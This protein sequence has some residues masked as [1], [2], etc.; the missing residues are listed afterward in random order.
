MVFSAPFQKESKTKSRTRKAPGQPELWNFA[1]DQSCTEIEKLPNQV[2]PPRERI[3][4][5]WKSN[6]MDIN[7]IAIV[8]Y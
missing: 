8:K 5:R 4:L 7:I 1:E 6:G 3:I 2:S